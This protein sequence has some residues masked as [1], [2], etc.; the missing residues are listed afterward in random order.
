MGNDED[1]ASDDNNEIN[2]TA[3]VPATTVYN[4]EDMASDDNNEINDTAGVPAT[5]VYNDED[6]ASNL[7]TNEND[8]LLTT[9]SDVVIQN[10]DKDDVSGNE[11]VESTARLSVVKSIPIIKRRDTQVDREDVDDDENESS[12]GDSDM[13]EA[14]Y[15]DEDA[16]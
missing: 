8:E 11:I 4:D 14:S 7:I 10:S 9:K 2:D 16:D 13:S 5:T 1:M 6:M 12:E 3:G 15:E